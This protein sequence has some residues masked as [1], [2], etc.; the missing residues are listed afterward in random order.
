MDK[1]KKVGIHQYCCDRGICR[2]DNYDKLILAYIDYY[3]KRALKCKWAFL[4]IS[5]AK[6][7]LIGML[8]VFQMTE[9]LGNFPWIITVLSSGTLIIESILELWRLKEKWILYRNTC[10]RLMAVQRQY[11]ETIEDKD[12]DLEKYISAIEYIINE[13]GNKWLETFRDKRTK[14][15]TRE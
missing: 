9:V 1:N 15:Y 13:E 11:A 14:N 5:L 10:N 2:R 4:I 12:S 8:P 7:I 3:H 6:I